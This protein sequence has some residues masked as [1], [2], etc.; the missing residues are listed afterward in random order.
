MTDFNVKG[1]ASL[2]P[3]KIIESV[4]AILEKLDELRDKIDEVDLTIDR[5]SGKTL[6]IGV[7]I[8]GEDKLVFLREL[9]D[10]LDSRDYYVNIKVDIDGEDKIEALK[11]EID[12]LDAKDHNVRMKIDLNGV[13]QATADL[14]ALDAELNQ[15]EEDFKKAEKS[16]DGFKFSI[17]SLLPVLTAIIPVVLAAGAG[18]IALAGA[19]GV[20][21]PGIIGIAL[22]AKP[23]FTAI[24]NLTKSLDANTKTALANADSYKQINSI[25]DKNSAAF[26]QMSPALRNLTVEWFQLQ[27]AYSAFQKAVDPAVFSMLGQGINLLRTMLS[28]LPA[29]VIPASNA[30]KSWL[31]DFSN[32]LHD[33]V[34]Q[35]FFSDAKKNIGGFVTDWSTGLLNIIEGITALLHAFMP[36]S[37]SISDGFL[38][39]TASFDK[40]AQSVGKTQGFQQFLAYV[41]KE[42]PIVL[43][44]LSQLVILLGKVTGSLMGMGAGS[45]GIID[46]ILQGINHFADANPAVFKLAVNFG[47][48][49]IAAG[50]LLPILAPL[51]EFLTSPVG[52][53]VVAVAALAIVFVDLYT[54]S[55][56]FHDWVNANLLPLWNKLVAAGQQFVTWAKGLWQPILEIWNKYGRQIEAIIKAVWDIVVNVIQGAIKVVEGIVDVFL[57]LLTGHW[58]RVWKGLTEIV[59]GVWQAI[60]SIVIEGAKIVGNLFV[61]FG[62]LIWGLVN[63]A[64][65]GI[66]KAFK[67]GFDYLF[68]TGKNMW[69]AI[70]STA[71]QWRTDI[72]NA[73]TGAWNDVN[74]YFG[75]IPGR[76]LKALGDLGSLLYNAGKAVL[77]G[78]WNGMKSVWNDVTGWLGDIGGWISNLKGPIEKDAVLLTPHGKA[79]IGGLMDGMQSQMPAMASQL[80]GFAKTIENSFGSQYTTD[81]SA[82]VRASLGSADYNLANY[83]QGGRLPSATGT[84]V[85]FA[86]GSI[87]VHNPTQEQPGVTLTRV[88]QGAAKF[89]TIQAPVGYSTSGG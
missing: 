12:D 43:N 75:G 34:F 1:T 54:K 5:L 58:S 64:W 35:S 71:E 68:N 2:D 40:W 72:W 80:K 17:M 55:K 18:V 28:G 10:D 15:K 19:F 6:D 9:L 57:G 14:V 3:D 88:L 81:I 48:I 42:G 27:N 70:I 38:H 65:D 20:M 47:L 32:R 59:N 60:S 13:D 25:L 44:T 29:L 45:L 85:T 46:R 83:Q 76:L 11:L 74:N 86:A 41:Q 69:K 50:K 8:D 84:Q 7:N 87:V 66:G 16:S 63:S 21:A 4:E 36:V 89:G 37:V 23:A 79:I 78:L 49:A 61:A 77:Q 33:P 82:R 30:L 39:M 52:I 22:A 67:A 26:R 24:Q 56:A 62:K 51:F 31:T 53:A 73:I